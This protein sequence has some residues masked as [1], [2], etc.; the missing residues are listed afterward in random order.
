ML[1]TGTVTNRVAPDSKS[2]TVGTS[3]SEGSP[4]ENSV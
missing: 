1:V 3:P 4:Q 2:T